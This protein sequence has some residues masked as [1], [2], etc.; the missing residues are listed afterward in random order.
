[1]LA[2]DQMPLQVA[3][4]RPIVAAKTTALIRSPA[5]GSPQTCPCAPWLPHQQGT[6][7][8]ELGLDRDEDWDWDWEGRRRIGWLG[9][10]DAAVSDRNGL[11]TCVV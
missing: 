9:E 10:S 11:L 7:V 3:W 4:A 6:P 8:V 5:G 1:M 2:V